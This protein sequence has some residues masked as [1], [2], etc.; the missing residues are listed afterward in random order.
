ME[1][2]TIYLL[3]THTGTLLSRMINFYTK[4]SLNHVSIGFDK[5][6]TE[7]YSFGRKRPK[8]PFIGGFVREDIRS[9]FL[10]HSNCAVYTFQV[11][12]REYHSILRSI[13]EIEAQKGN[14]R[15]NFIGL[16]GILFKIKIQRKSAFFCSQF[17]A[18]ILQEVHTF[19]MNKPFCF[20]TPEDIRKHVGMT[21]IYEGKLCDYDHTEIGEKRIDLEQ[22]DRDKKDSVLLTFSQ[23]IKQ[24]VFR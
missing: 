23:K 18:T 19:E 15:Y 21:L 4:H 3:F 17:V 24:F 1:K 9:N 13:Q 11:T 8:N 12:E 10:R 7:V 16:I 14:Y 2:R 5:R 6:L 22:A 20:V